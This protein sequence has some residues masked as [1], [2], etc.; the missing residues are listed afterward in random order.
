[1][2]GAGGRGAHIDSGGTESWTLRPAVTVGGHGGFCRDECAPIVFKPAQEGRRGDCESRALMAIARAQHA[3]LPYALD[4]F[5]QVLGAAC[6]EDNQVTGFAA[7]CERLGTPAE[8]EDGDAAL[9][10]A[11]CAAHHARRRLVAQAGAKASARAALPAVAGTCARRMS[12]A[13]LASWRGWG[14]LEQRLPL[15]VC[16]ARHSGDGVGGGAECG[17]PAGGA[18]YFAMRDVCAGMRRPCVAD[19]KIG[20][21]M[22]APG[23]SSRKVLADEGKCSMQRATGF[24]ITA[25][26]VWRTKATDKGSEEWQCSRYGRG[27]CFALTPA[28]ALQALRFFFAARAKPM[29]RMRAGSAPAPASSSSARPA[30][31]SACLRS[32]SIGRTEATSSHGLHA[33]VRRGKAPEADAVG[34]QPALG[35]P[36]RRE[37]A[38]ELAARAALC[39][40]WCARASPWHLYGSSILLAYDADP[41]TPPKSPAGGTHSTQGQPPMRCAPVAKLIDFAHARDVDEAWSSAWGGAVQ[42]ARNLA[43]ALAA[44]ATGQGHLPNEP[45]CGDAA[46]FKRPA[47]PDPDSKPG[48]ELKAAMDLADGAV[49]MSR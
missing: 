6:V 4:I 43:D 49:G 20:S 31:P 19:V 5:P 11:K 16:A 26:Q 1:M 30:Q 13:E 27:F 10:S 32:A 24:R 42:G 35:A 3:S 48:A 44:V 41:V 21:Q 7:P 12:D 28:T 37:A 29:P 14:S 23:S 17:G 18:L 15:P 40:D 8:T 39:A 45:L 47:S 25:M 46:V 22:W 2:A 36:L 33:D 34:R 38:A 9:A